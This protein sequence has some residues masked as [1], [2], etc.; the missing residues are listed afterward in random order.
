M[1]PWIG[2]STVMSRI[3]LSGMVASLRL[4]R[5]CTRN[6]RWLVTT[7]RSMLRWRARRPPQSI[8]ASPT[9][10]GAQPS[11]TEENG[12]S[13]QQISPNRP[14]IPGT[15]YTIQCLCTTSTMSSSSSRSSR[16]PMCGSVSQR[17]TEPMARLGAERLEEADDAV[18][19]LDQQ[20]PDGG[21]GLLGAR[22]E[23]V[24]ILHQPEA[25][26][27]DQ[28]EDDRLL[29]GACHRVLLG[30]GEGWCAPSS[31]THPHLCSKFEA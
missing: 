8:N 5:P 26:E 15:T 21:A 31:R 19:E 29:Q 28:E 16:S 9:R 10:M 2:F 25:E 17:Q 20:V 27:Q 22:S 12:T 18:E 3:L 6:T 13:T 11:C 23:A 7:K 30:S 4:N 1:R 14:N 24:G